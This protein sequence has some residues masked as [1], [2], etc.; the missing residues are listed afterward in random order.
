[1][2][3]YGG[4]SMKP[5]MGSGVFKQLMGSGTCGGSFLPAGYRGGSFIPAG[6]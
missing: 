5:R 2:G 6:V 4:N 3:G 1:M